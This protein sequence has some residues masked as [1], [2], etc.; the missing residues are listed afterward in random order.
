MVDVSESLLGDAEWIR[1]EATLGLDGDTQASRGQYFTPERAA[2][3][4]AGMPRLW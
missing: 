3:L 4:I 1:V 2:A